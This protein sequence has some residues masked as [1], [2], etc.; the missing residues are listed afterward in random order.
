V[1]GGRSQWPA[2]DVAAHYVA[3]HYV[4]AHRGASRLAPENTLA[5]FSAALG[6]GAMA[7]ELDVHLTRDGRA[8]VIHDDLVDRTTDGR[9]PVRLLDSDE[10][11]RLDAGSWW[12]AEFAGQPV[13]FLE[14]VIEL[15]EGKA[16]L[17]IELKGATAQVLAGEVVAMARRL[18][19]SAR[20]VV[21]SFDLDAALA[22]RAAAGPDLP[23][24]AI[25]G[26]TLEDQLGFVIATGLSGLNQAVGRWRPETVQRFHE[27]GLLV[28]GSLVNDRRQ[29][30][31]F[32]ALGGD[33]ADSDSPDCFGDGA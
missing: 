3:A 31:E 5:A 24:V 15:T 22:A 9:G 23:V 19:A 18:G 17:H 16:C 32:F 10:V 13:P 2:H 26:G 33:M 14:E 11:R 29:L 27:R 6:R 8:V 12:S 4:A 7:L 25:V 28:H 1:T 21:M 20:V 30:E